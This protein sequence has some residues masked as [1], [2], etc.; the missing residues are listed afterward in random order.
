MTK[1]TVALGLMSGT[2]MDG[3]DVAMLKTDGVAAVER[4]GAASFAYPATFRDRL[5]QALADAQGLTARE[6]RPGS[7]AVVE[8]ELTER[9]ATVV[10]DFLAS[11]GAGA[12][13]VDLIGF[14]G[15]TVLH[16][17]P[18]LVSHTAPN[19]VPW[20]STGRGLTVQLGDGPMLAKLTGIHVVYDLRAADMAA[21]GHGAPLA[22]AF[23]AALGAKA[24]LHPVAF[25][26]L[27]GVGNLTWIST[28][29][30]A[31]IAFDTGPGNAL[32]DDF[33][34]A[35]SGR[36]RDDGGEL[37]LTGTVDPDALTTLLRNDYFGRLP[38]KSL[39][40]NAF[41]LAPVMHLSDA[42]GAATLVAFTAAAVAC[43]VSMVPEPPQL[44]LVAGGGRHNRA[45]M[46]ALAERLDAA[47]A[48]VEAIGCNGD[49]LEAEA[50]A[51]LA[52]RSQLGL[53]ISWP[54]TTGVPMAMT[55]GAFAAP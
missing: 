36:P 49:T 39:D 4:V 44:W 51:Y 14:H 25:L 21:G 32:I 5:R 26:N 45:I 54:R 48:P 1:L 23:H 18:A 11:I 40:R 10:S 53:P 7:L 38:P 34:Q 55:G 47:V 19:G 9:H 50:W 43:A 15:Q 8:R 42:D 30:S 41:S 35:R 24:P 17:P 2:S 12:G 20:Q 29:G 13:D 6:Q 31:P 28:A 33:M 27:G 3:I 16:R 37:A 52:V 22:P 46:A